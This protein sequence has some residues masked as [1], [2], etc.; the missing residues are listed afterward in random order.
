MGV[1]T[2][3]T[4]PPYVGTPGSPDEVKIILFGAVGSN[5]QSKFFS[6]GAAVGTR[7]V[8]T[9]YRFSAALIIDP[10]TNTKSVVGLGISPK[11]GE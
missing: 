2:L 6:G 9:P 3:L 4:E 1:A 8:F 10:A 7:V 11:S 5:G